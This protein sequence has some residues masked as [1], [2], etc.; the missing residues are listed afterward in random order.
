MKEVKYTVSVIKQDNAEIPHFLVKLGGQTIGTVHREGKVS[1]EL[2]TT[3]GERSLPLVA[4]MATSQRFKDL[5]K[6]LG[7]TVD[8]YKVWFKLV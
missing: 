4:P 6:F 2:E 5:I 3:T 7:C 1:M 8:V